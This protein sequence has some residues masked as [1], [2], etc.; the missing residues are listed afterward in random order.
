[1]DNLHDYKNLSQEELIQL[2]QQKDQV[3][4]NK[5]DEI[6]DIKE[7]Y[8]E[9]YS[10]VYSPYF[11]SHPEI[12]QQSFNFSSLIDEEGYN[13]RDVGDAENK[14]DNMNDQLKDIN[15]NIK[16]TN[17]DIFCD[18]VDVFIQQLP[19]NKQHIG[20][21]SEWENATFINNYIFTGQLAKILEA[22]YIPA[23]T[24]FYNFKP[25]NIFKSY[26]LHKNDLK[27]C[28]K[29]IDEYINNNDIDG[30]N[31]PQKIKKLR[32][33]FSDIDSVLSL[34]EKIQ[35][36]KAINVTEFSSENTKKI[37]KRI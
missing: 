2:L 12:E 10:K 28:H 34:L 17:S 3:I 14:F 18:A 19:D 24:L 13:E 7:R 11:I 29:F 21:I 6:N 5:N 25:E 20:T 15:E 27:N 37:T 9:L 33:Y 26:S 8:S 16:Q 31:V 1:M 32:H 35:L 36:E 22:T 23:K 30:N 4:N